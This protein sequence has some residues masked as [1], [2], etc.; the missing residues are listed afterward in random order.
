M[1]LKINL[2]YSPNFDLKKRSKKEIKFL[3]FH[4]TGMK[5]ETK[6]IERL[7]SIKSKVSSHYL[8]KNNGDVLVLVPDLYIA[9][10]AGKSYW[11]NFKFL[12][13]NSIGIE[14][15]NPGH[16][17]KYS[18]YKKKQI[19]SILKLSKFLIL[20][21]KIKSKNILGHSDIA[22]ARKKDP[23][24]NFPWNLLAKQKIGIWHSL[25][26]KNLKK[27]RLKKISTIDKKYFF[28]NLLKIGYTFNNKTNLR[29]ENYKGLLIKAFQRRY[30]QQ[31]INGKIDK[32]CLLISKNIAKKL[33]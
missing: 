8:I 27:N 14:I 24:E 23:G 7:T 29:Y 16:Q 33:N 4:Y 5:K 3:I 18:K 12:N 25:S 30:R 11:K 20:K 13:K 1:G 28:K 6:S 32:E 19:K 26:E 15:S 17:Y 9:W 2:N 10:H 22:P 21:Y 31:I